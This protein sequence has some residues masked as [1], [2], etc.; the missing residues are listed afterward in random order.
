M[1]RLN[2]FSPPL[3][4]LASLDQASKGKKQVQN[5]TT[6]GSGGGREGNKEGKDKTKRGVTNKRGPAFGAG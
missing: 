4:L 3:P 2:S 1:T 6:W 5:T